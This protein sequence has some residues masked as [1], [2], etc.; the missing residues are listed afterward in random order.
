MIP[1]D[2]MRL[3]D[4]WIGVPLCW[5]AS[6]LRSTRRQNRRAL[7]SKR[8]VFV[9]L[10]ESGSNV[11]ADPAVRAWIDRSG[12]RPGYVTFAANRQSL[13]ITATIADSDVFALDSGSLY[14][15]LRDAWRLRRWLCERRVDTLVDLELFTRFSALLC[16]AS[17]VPRRVGFHAAGGGGLYRGN[18]YTDPVICDFGQHISRNYQA[19]TATLTG[20][21]V[22]PGVPRVVQRVITRS[23]QARVADTLSRLFP[24]GSGP[25]VL[26]NA[27]ASDLLPQR[28]WPLAN[29]QQF[30]EGLLARYAP[31]R[32]LLTGGSEDR[33]TTGA[34]ARRVG[35]ARCVDGAA[36]VDLAHLPA[37]FDQAAL[38]LTNDSGPAHF[39]AVTTLPVLVLFGPETPARFA[40]LG[41]ATVFSAGLPCSPCVHPANQ[42]RSGC[43]DNRCLQAIPVESVLSHAVAILDEATGAR[44]PAGR[45]AEPMAGSGSR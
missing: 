25:L 28:R 7:S 6:R 20:E 2:R 43:D 5:L 17:G 40:P 15:L 34:L 31:I 3:L 16:F 38:L 32:I 21:P 45:L 41:N 24:E 13:R 9:Q 23:E 19:L 39:A 18:L 36:R 26:V 44:V 1:V 42:R 35:D 11:L 29:F 10:A 14:T 22:P 8:V 12:D 27:N 30:V 37:L 33:E 4:R